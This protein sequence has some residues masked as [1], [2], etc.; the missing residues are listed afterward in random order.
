MPSH[1]RPALRVL[2]VAALLTILF[3]QL[4]AVNRRTSMSWDEG[5][6][7]FDGYTILKHH[8]FDPNPEVPPFA[9]V[10]AAIP[11][12][13]DDELE[14]V[15]LPAGQPS[16][17]AQFKQL[18]PTAILDGGLFVYQGHFDI[19]AASALVGLARPKQPATP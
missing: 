19:S 11:L 2:A 3:L 16:P 8:D 13:P 15:D 6:H 12:L 14:G 5:H 10:V 9:K 1:P 7:L 17:D 4:L 18:K